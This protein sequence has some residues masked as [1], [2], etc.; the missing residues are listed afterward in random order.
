MKTTVQNAG[1]RSAL[2]V[3]V[4]TETHPPEINGVA[5]TVGLMVD[6]LCERGHDVQLVRPRQGEKGRLPA[7][8]G[9]DERL[10]PG[11]AIPFYRHLQMGIAPPRLL[12]KEWTKWRPDVVHV[13]TEGP[14]GWQAVSTARDLEI[15]VC[16]DFHTN[17]H[18]YSR[19]YGM[20]V[21]ANLVS[22]YLRTLH[23]RTECTMVP[24]AEMRACLETMG[25]E[26]VDV[27]GRGV[28]SGLFSPACRSERL[29]ASW[30]CRGNETVALYVGRLAPEKNL[31]LFVEAAL[32]MREVDAEL[33]VVLVG[34]GPQAADLRARYPDFVFAGTRTGGDLAEHYAS[35]DVF[36]FPSVTETFGNVT[37]EAMASG[38]AVAAYDYAAARQYLRNQSSALLAPVHDRAAFI[39]IAVRLAQ[40]AELRARLRNEARRVAEAAS[41]SRAFDDLER[42][43]RNTA[44]AR[45]SAAGAVREESAHVET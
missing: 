32:A 20:G 7:D 10:V 30:G 27:V 28:D 3:A 6:A 5:G 39:R 41:W 12:R 13:V 42:V 38:L 43:L 8:D 37:L 44:R 19:H 17:F 2:R 15:P 45:P 9:P 23:N 18:S 11:F 4:V 25:F 40:A 26:R 35:A 36:V 16:S 24:T 29:R 14:L 31:G 1:G 22:R 33:R 34:D 21:F